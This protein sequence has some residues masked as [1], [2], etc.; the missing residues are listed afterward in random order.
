M[1]TSV[2]AIQTSQ[3]HCRACARIG[4]AYAKKG[5]KKEALFWLGKS[6]SEHRDQ[7]IV[8]KHKQLEKELAESERLAYID[9]AKA[10]EEKSLGNAAF[11][12]CYT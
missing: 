11:R 8:K 6:L 9:P 12:K 2:C 3:L 4:N 5:E 7:E 1:L 10:D